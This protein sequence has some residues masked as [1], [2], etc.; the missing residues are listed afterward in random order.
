MTEIYI[1]QKQLPRLERLAAPGKVLVVYGPRRVGK[2]TLMQRYVRQCARDA[3][4]VSGE[5][6]AV[7]EYLE[8]QSIAKLRA[9]A[10]RTNCCAC[11]SCSPSRSAGRF[12]WRRWGAR[13]A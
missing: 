6:V 11:C 9:F 2:T 3:L 8:S 5:D 7:R 13:S 1:P 10:M 4:V 12:R